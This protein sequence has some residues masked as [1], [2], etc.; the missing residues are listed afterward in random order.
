MEIDEIQMKGRK[1]QKISKN[2]TDAKKLGLHNGEDEQLGH[3]SGGMVGRLSCC[4]S[5]RIVRASRGSG[6]KDRHSKV[7]TSK[8][9]RDRRVR[10]SVTTAIQFYDLQDR[11]GYDQP[12]KAIDWLLK[13]ATD[14]ISELPPLDASFSDISDEIGAIVTD[15]VELTQQIQC[16]PKSGCSSSTSETSKVSESLSLSRSANRIKSRELNC[17]SFTELLTGIDAVS[18]GISQM[19]YYNT[20]PGFKLAGDQNQFS[21]TNENVAP[22][23]TSMAEEYNSGLAGFNRGT[24]QSNTPS[25][26][27]HFQR[28]SHLDGSNL[29]S[30]LPLENQNHHQ[31]YQTG[32]DGPLQLC[33]GDNGGC[34]SDQKGKDKN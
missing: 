3:G 10:L 9:L 5:S 17:S 1:V 2:G 15:D 27:P 30:Y 11:L 6:G 23:V 8:G 18:H 20:F 7:L 34:Y 28:F 31:I 14:S 13:K 33:F 4:P 22:I 24:L 29:A 32:I 25:F 21:F 16:L 26:Y 19:D 12:S